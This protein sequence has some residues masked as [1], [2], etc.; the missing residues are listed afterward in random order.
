MHP[1]PAICGILSTI[2]LLFA[3]LPTRAQ[4]HKVEAPEKVT[5]A[6]GV[7]EWTG[8]LAKPTAARLIPVSLF[9]GGHFEDAG[10][11][12]AHPVPFV[13][14]TGD[15]YSIE[16]AGESIG[17]FDLE[18]ARDIRTRHSAADD[19]PLGAWYG[20]GHF[21]TP[22]EEAKLTKLHAAKPPVVVASLDADNDNSRPQ[23]VR[24][25]GTPSTSTGT[26]P[27][28]SKPGAATSTTTPAPD[29]DPDRPTLRHRDPADDA[30]R[31]K[32]G[33]D[34]PMGYVTPPNTS[35]NEDPDRPKLQ[36]G[37]PVGDATTQQL[38]G[39]PP[40]LHQASAISDAANRDA[41][42]FTREWVT[43]TE[44]AETL[45]TL[46]ALAQ[47]RLAKYIT[48]NKLTPATVA[49]PVSGPAFASTPK[50]STPTKTT[51]HSRARKSG[52]PPAPPITLANEQLSG[53][54][55]SYG[56]LP[57]FIYTG[58]V[59]LANGGPVY[60]TM[61]AQHLPSGELQVAF[62][63]VTD[64]AHLDRTP[65]FR[66]IDVVDPDWSHRGSLLF[67]LRAQ[68]S[69]QFALYRLITAQAEQTFITGIIE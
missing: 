68:S 45:I 17:T 52:S 29:D 61:V 9:V 62:V 47:P 33:K 6:L 13:L 28:S 49:K 5:R 2:A 46:E 21:L 67:E 43:S 41:H 20:Y 56:G 48:T 15:V 42:V 51:T 12:L 64:A 36:R 60:L 35:L 31:K 3:S 58:E 53:Y 32:P 19:D 54:T 8:D 38:S 39:T 50:A 4:M 66:P 44:R 57:T 22:T 1:R 40:D 59:P 37:I 25:Q 27:P 10:V 16:R 11:Y 34:K 14:Q 26:L 63:S 65:W 69:R 24:R 23:F 30:Q 18:Y 55:L 7:Y